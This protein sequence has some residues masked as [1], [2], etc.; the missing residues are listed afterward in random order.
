M[1]ME[2]IREHYNVNAFRGQR[3]EIY[4]GRE[5]TITG[6]RSQYLRVRLDGDKHTSIV[7]PTWNIMY[8]DGPRT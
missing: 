2:Y 5:G 1:S 3:V 4:N 6:S 8:L 7:H